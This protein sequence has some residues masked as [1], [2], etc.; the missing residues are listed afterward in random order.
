MTKKVLLLKARTS[1]SYFAS[2][3]ELTSVPPPKRSENLGKSVELM[4]HF[5]GIPE[6]LETVSGRPPILILDLFLVREAPSLNFHFFVEFFEF[7]FPVN[8]CAENA[9]AYPCSL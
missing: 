4:F 2:D 1:G 3:E 9:R 6:S 8:P 5:E 7:V